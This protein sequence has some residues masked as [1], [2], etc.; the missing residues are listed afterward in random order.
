MIIINYYLV[1]C[2]NNNIQTTAVASVAT[3]T[4]VIKAR[5]SLLLLQWEAWEAK[6]NTRITK[7]VG[8][9]QFTVSLACVCISISMH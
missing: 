4:Q 3:T 8:H 6:Q 9:C 7:L 2:N 1:M 5:Q